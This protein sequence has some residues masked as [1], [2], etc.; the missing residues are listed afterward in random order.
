MRYRE[1]DYLF[2]R[3]I[4]MCRSDLVPRLYAQI[5]DPLKICLRRRFFAEDA[6]SK[7]FGE[8]LQILTTIKERTR[9]RPNKGSKNTT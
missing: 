9:R 3:S 8:H 5:E 2:H 7:S 1:L 6:V 4:I